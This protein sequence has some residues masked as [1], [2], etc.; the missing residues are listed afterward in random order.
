[1]FD[2]FSIKMSKP[3]DNGAAHPYRMEVYEFLPKGP[4]DPKELQ[5]QLRYTWSHLLVHAAMS[6]VHARNINI[7]IRLVVEQPRAL[8]RWCCLIPSVLCIGLSIL[9]A[10]FQLGRFFYMDT[11]SLYAGWAI[12]ISML[13]YSTILLQKAY[14]MSLKTRWIL[15]IGIILIILQTIAP[16][17]MLNI[18]V[19]VN[20]DF[21]RRGYIYYSTGWVFIWFCTSLAVNLFLSSVFSY[22]AY[23]Q[24]RKYGSKTWKRL[25]SDGIQFMCLAILCNIAWAVVVFFGNISDLF[26]LLCFIDCGVCSTI[27]VENCRKTRDVLTE[28]SLL[29]TE[30]AIRILK[31][32]SSIY[33]ETNSTTVS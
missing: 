12:P 2:S 6:Y 22:M 7:A 8:A 14:I 9:T 10:M 16:I 11:T 33:E 5:T 18:A 4:F 30:R 27:L 20:T 24:Y 13:C 19:I 28:A 17:M 15:V 31:M 3:Y 1:M 23:R 25:A 32:P 21:Y 29:K 26:L